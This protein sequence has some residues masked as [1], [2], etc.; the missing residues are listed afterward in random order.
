MAVTALIP[1]VLMPWLDVA[2]SK[3]LCQNYLKVSVASV[4]VAVSQSV[5]LH[6]GT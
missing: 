5:S 3:T 4:C 1:V 6:G 2:G